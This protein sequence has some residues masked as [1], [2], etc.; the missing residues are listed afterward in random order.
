M[1]RGN[2][3]VNDQNRVPKPKSL[4]EVPAYLRTLF[5]TFF[6]RL[7]YI[8]ALSWEAKPSLVF[9]MAFICVFNGVAP[10]IGAM[11]GARILNA[12]SQV[13]PSVSSPFC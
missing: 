5:V 4:K 9:A 2:A 8:F 3:S 6:S 10:V 1:P 7:F 12:L 11:I 13:W